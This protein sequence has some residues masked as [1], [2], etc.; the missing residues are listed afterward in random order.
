MAKYGQY[1]FGEDT[2]F[3]TSYDGDYTEAVEVT[4]PEISFKEMFFNNGIEIPT[5]LIYKTNG[6][7][8]TPEIQ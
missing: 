2:E 6:Y 4:I 1:N 3:K 7:V 5:G 8:V